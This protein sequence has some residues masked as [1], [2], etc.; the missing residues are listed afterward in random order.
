MK[1]AIAQAGLLS[2]D[3]NQKIIILKEAYTTLADEIDRKGERISRKA[4]AAN[5]YSPTEISGTSLYPRGFE[6]SNRVTGI[7]RIR[8]P[9]FGD[10][11][12]A[13]MPASVRLLR[14]SP[15][16]VVSPRAGK[17][18]CGRVFLKKEGFLK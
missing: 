12:S 13:A 1:K 6:E 2:E 16:S 8:I 3:P 10:L 17:E 4:G 9:S 11:A 15:V 7:T 18:V 14:G 5:Q